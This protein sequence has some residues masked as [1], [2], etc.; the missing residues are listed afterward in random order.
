MNTFDYYDRK[1]EWSIE[2]TEQLRMEYIDKALTIMQI[3]Y[4]HKRTPGYISSKLRKMKIISVSNQARGYFEY[5]NSELYKEVVEKYSKERKEKLPDYEKNIGN[6]WTSEEDSQLISEYNSNVNI[7]EICRIHRR[8]IGGITSRLKRL[9]CI[10]AR[11]DIK[12]YSRNKREE[13]QYNIK[14]IID[15]KQDIKEMKQDIK[16][17]I[18]TLKDIKEN[19]YNIKHIIDIVKDTK[20]ILQLLHKNG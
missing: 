1:E 19:Q 11:S 7:T 10:N 5:R 20:E 12:E 17:I 4:I 2:E 15:M 9:N 8:N 18:D 13:N 6:P 14:D 3:A 16:H